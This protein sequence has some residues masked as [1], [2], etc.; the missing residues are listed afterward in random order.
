MQVSLAGDKLK[1]R[2]QGMSFDL[3]PVAEYRFKIN[4]WLLKLGLAGLLNLPLDLRE[5]EIEF[6]MDAET[7]LVVMVINLAGFD[8]EICPR[9]SEP[10][11]GLAAWEAL[12]GEYQRYARLAPG[13][14][15]KIEL[16]QEEITVVDG[17]LHMSGAIGPILPLDASTIDILSGPF[18]Q[19]TI[20][21][22]AQSGFLYHQSHVYKPIAGL[23]VAS[24]P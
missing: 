22:D 16:G 19:E 20:S 6:Q 12:V 11:G 17:Q 5:L 7:D 3:I 2:I 15:T 1:G 24:L 13:D 18:N 8:Y 10:P 14:A 4:H 23:P 9:L 21:Y